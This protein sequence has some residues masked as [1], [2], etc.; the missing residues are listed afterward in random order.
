MWLVRINKKKTKAT[1]EVVK[2]EP[3]LYLNIKVSKNNEKYVE[4]H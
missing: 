3:S 4:L 2:M 1:T